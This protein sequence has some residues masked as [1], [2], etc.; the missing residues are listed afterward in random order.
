LP[1][2]RVLDWSTNGVAGHAPGL[3]LDCSQQEQTAKD[4]EEEGSGS[5]E[6]ETGFKEGTCSQEETGREEGSAEETSGEE[7]S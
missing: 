7:A 1:V 6:E 2:C 4:S 5:K 3:R